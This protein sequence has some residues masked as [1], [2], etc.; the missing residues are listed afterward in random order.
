MNFNSRGEADDLVWNLVWLWD[1][2]W[3]TILATSCFWNVVWCV[4]VV[5]TCLKKIAQNVKSCQKVIFR[6]TLDI[7]PQWHPKIFHSFKRRTPTVISEDLNLI[8]HISAHKFNRHW[9]QLKNILQNRFRLRK[10]SLHTR[11]YVSA[12]GISTHWLDPS[13]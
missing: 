9:C 10:K 3:E 11:Y 1:G 2:S 12:K 8:L 6:A 13:E 7:E 5:A 4:K